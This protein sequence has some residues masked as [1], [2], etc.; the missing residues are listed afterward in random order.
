MCKYL[1]PVINTLTSEG[2]LPEELILIKHVF[3]TWHNQIFKIQNQVY[4]SSKILFFFVTG[5]QHIMFSI[6]TVHIYIS[7]FPYKEAQGQAFVQPAYSN[8]YC[9]NTVILHYLELPL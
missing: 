9:C 3:Y 4:F 8:S 2:I 5:T 6:Q 1:F 7:Y